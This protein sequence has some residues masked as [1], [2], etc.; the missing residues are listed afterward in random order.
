MYIATAADEGGPPPRGTKGSN[1]PKSVQTALKNI[2]MQ[3]GTK[4]LVGT[5]WKKVKQWNC[6]F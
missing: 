3:H 6:R 1:L 4:D 2:K 5:S